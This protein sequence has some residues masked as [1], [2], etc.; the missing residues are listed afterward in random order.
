LLDVNPAYC[1]MV[2]YSRSELLQMH[3]SDLEVLENPAEIQAHLQKVRQ[4]GSHCFETCH[5]RKDGKVIDLA[6]SKLARIPKMK[7]CIAL[8]EILPNKIG[9]KMP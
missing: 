2:G 5:R 9:L 1:K 7:F 6:A 3:I 4:D 8:C